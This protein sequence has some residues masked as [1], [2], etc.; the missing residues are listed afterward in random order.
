MVQSQ[1][2]EGIQCLTLNL[3]FKDQLS[4]SESGTTVVHSVKEILDYT[5]FDYNIK[6]K[7]LSDL[8]IKDLLYSSDVGNWD[9]MLFQPLLHG[10]HSAGTLHLR[11]CL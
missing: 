10:S 9:I 1:N 5:A 7:W 8:G 3:Y 6:V 11:M 4:V 2:Q